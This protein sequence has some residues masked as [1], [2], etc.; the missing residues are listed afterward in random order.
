[1]PVASQSPTMTGRT[2]PKSRACARAPAIRFT[3]SAPRYTEIGGMAALSMP[4]SEYRTSEVGEAAQARAMP[5][6]RFFRT[7]RARVPRDG[8][9]SGS[10]VGN[11]GPVLARDLDLGFYFDRNVEGKV[12]HPDRG[13]R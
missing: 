13:A 7:L 1:M 4:S 8:S 11:A 10:G 2:S 6:R 5:W 3:S 9:L 12:R